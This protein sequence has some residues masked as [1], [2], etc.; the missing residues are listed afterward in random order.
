[1][2][3]IIVCERVLTRQWCLQPEH[4][5]W[6]QRSSNQAHAGG[7][8]GL[9]TSS[10]RRQF[11]SW[12]NRLLSNSW[13]LVQEQNTLLRLVKK[14]WNST[15]KTHKHTS[16]PWSSTLQVDRIGSSGLFLWNCDC[17]DVFLSDCLWFPAAR[18]WKCCMV[19][20]TYSPLYVSNLIENNI[21]TYWQTVNH[22]VQ[23]D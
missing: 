16:C 15:F 8:T 10:C 6:G 20:V 13:E 23:K 7:K 4:V 11:G 12:I 21:W 2:S 14:Y 9:K 19:L 22:Q 3:R 1:M 5:T 17:L 18:R